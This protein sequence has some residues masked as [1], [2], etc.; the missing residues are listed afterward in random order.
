MFT[1]LKLLLCLFVLTCATGCYRMP[2][3]DEYSLIP[4][5]NNPKFTKE[6]HSATPGLGY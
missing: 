2:E 6:T 4:A 1:S 3:P 5:T